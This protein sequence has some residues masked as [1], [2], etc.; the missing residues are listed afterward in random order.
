MASAT[1]SASPAPARSR[2][3]TVGSCR[4]FFTSDRERCSIRSATAVHVAETAQR[5]LDLPRANRLRRR[6]APRAAARP[7]ARGS[8][9]RRPRPPPRRSPRPS[10]S[11][12]AA[13]PSRRRVPRADRRRRRGG[14]LRPRPRRAR[15]LPVP[16]DRRA[17]A[18]DRHARLAARTISAATT[19]VS[20]DVAAIA[21]SASASAASSSSSPTHR[22]RTGRRPP[23]RAPSSGSR[24]RGAVSATLGRLQGLQADPAGADDE[25]ALV[26]DA[27]HPRRAR[28]P[29]SS[30]WRDSRRAPSPRALGGRRRSRSGRAARA[31]G[32][33]PSR[34][35]AGR[36]T[37]L[38]ED[39]RLAEHERVEPGRHPPEVPRDVDS[40]VDVEVVEEELT[41]DVVRPRERVDELVARV[42]DPAGQ[43]RVQLHAVA[44]LEHGVLEDGRAPLRAEAERADALPQLDGSRSMAQSDADEAVHAVETLLAHSW[45][46]I[47]PCAR[48][49]STSEAPSRTRCS[50]STGD[51]HGEGPDRRAPAG[52]RRRGCG[53]RRRTARRPL[54][55]RHD[56]RHERSARAPRRANGARHER[57]LRARPPPATPDASAPVPALRGTSSSARPARALR[58][59]AG[60]DRP[61][62]R[63]R[64]ARSRLAAARRCRRD[65]RLASLL[66]PRPAHE[67]SVAEELR[68]RHPE[69]H[70]VAS[71]EV[72][73]EFR[74]YER[75]STTA[76]DAYLGPVLARY[77]A[78][79]R[80]LRGGGAP[81]RRSSCARRAASR[82]STRPPRTPR[83]RCSPGRQPASSAQLAR[84]ARR[85]RERPLLRHGRDVDGRVRDRRRRRATRARA[86]RRTASRC[87]CP[88]SRCTP[89]A[90]AAARSSGSTKAARC[91]SARRARGAE[92]G[93]ACYGRGGTQADGHRRQPAAR[94][95]ASAL[96][97]GIELDR[98]AAERALGDIDA[99]AV[100]D[101]VDAEMVRALRVVSVEQGLD[102]R[103][104]ALVAFGGAGPL[105]ACALAEE[106][107][108]GTV[109][110]P[111]A[112]GVLSALG[113]VAAD[114]RRDA[115][116][117]YVRRSTRPA[118]SRGRRGRPA[119]RGPV[120]RAGRS[121][122]PAPRRA[123][124]RG[125]RGA[126]RLRGS[127][128][129][130]RARR[131]ANRRRAPGAAD[132]VT[133]PAQSA[134]GPQV[135]ELDGATAWVPAGWE[136][137]TDE[138][139]TLVLGE[140]A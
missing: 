41:R 138:H 83:S 111:A 102:P 134:A 124:P 79:S 53:G 123:L 74:E 31:P 126:L 14:R 125:T 67:R 29:S 11:R 18:G 45:S 88:R 24:P 89:W 62:R 128:A 42:L 17:R 21:T 59:R 56:D 70:V 48:S 130:A 140:R 112:A 120:L 72:A 75:A 96:P 97:G 27:E 49:G 86:A 19:G 20:E 35:A 63:A 121:A 77:L 127:R 1:S 43:P 12:G 116:R 4:S 73:P 61:R 109:L 65:R 99:A 34:A 107:G 36:V 8:A 98:E 7:R 33:R 115:V 87:G 78:P 84:R 76:V 5:A 52:V 135:L 92:P 54:H 2:A 9:A 95:P 32:R 22:R 38:A 69:A 68:R 133:G 114:E 136:G 81:R 108:M 94:A 106:L 50:S 85:V 90:R 118:S 10:G 103:D 37:D 117:T 64:A 13:T 23:L 71:H 57:G 40:G 110:V 3:R 15:R 93:P 28:A 58:R 60:T 137:A 25:Q 80:R 26:A 47:P 139:G 46:N 82:R 104:F 51:S 105:H 66:L 122:R 119:L 129:C 6:A 44:R 91:G 113:L 100:V 16:R 101:V 30:R 131:R 132:R 39:L 55:A